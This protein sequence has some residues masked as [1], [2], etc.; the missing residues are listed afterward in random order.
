MI[1]V[2]TGVLA[3]AFTVGTVIVTFGMAVGIAAGVSVSGAVA[4]ATVDF[5]AGVF[6]E[7][8]LEAVAGAGDLLV[9]DVVFF[10]AVMVF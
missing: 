10:I 8:G 6:F 5:A 2:W 1:L 4:T 9:L 3:V 7:G